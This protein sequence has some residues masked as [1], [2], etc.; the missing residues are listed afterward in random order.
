MKDNIE[1]VHCNFERNVLEREGKNNYR[2]CRLN[3]NMDPKQNI[4]KYM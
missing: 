4:F 3:M 1:N 2:P